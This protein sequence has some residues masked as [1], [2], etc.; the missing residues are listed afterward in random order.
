M[1][2]RAS[3]RSQSSLDTP[4]LSCIAAA[5][6]ERRRCKTMRTTRHAWSLEDVPFM[7]G[8]VAPS[9]AQLERPSPHRLSH[10]AQGTPR[11]LLVTEI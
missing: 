8:H 2:R 11:R 10:A 3:H 5:A 7:E 1:P 6:L 9:P 4:E